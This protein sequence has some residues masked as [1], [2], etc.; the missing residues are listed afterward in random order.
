MATSPRM[1]PTS[2]HV[3]VKYHWFGHHVGNEFFIWKTESENQSTNNFTKVL[4]G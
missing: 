1:T 3:T 4:Q 2:K